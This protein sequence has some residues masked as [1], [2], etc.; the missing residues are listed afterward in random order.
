M[1]TRTD[2]STAGE[3]SASDPVGP[4][5]DTN[6]RSQRAICYPETKQSTEQHFPP[7]KPTY[8]KAAAD[9]LAGQLLDL[10]H[11][12]PG[13]APND[14]A[15]CL[16]LGRGL[17]E[18]AKAKAASLVHSSRFRDFIS[19]GDTPDSLL[20]NGRDDLGAVEG[21]SPLSLVAAELVH[22]CQQARTVFTTSFFCDRRRFK[23]ETT[24]VGSPAVGLMSSL[25]G[26]ILSQM[27]QRG[28]V[29]NLAFLTKVDWHNVEKLK[30][31]ILSIIF[32]E[33]INQLPAGSVLVCVIDEVSLYET[34]LHE[35]E[36]D[37][38]VRRLARLSVRNDG[39]IFKL[40]VACR[41]RP[42]GVGR[43]FLGKTIDL[44]EQVET[45]D[46]A[47]SQVSKLSIGF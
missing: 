15:T 14:V 30:L 4:P 22:R 16:R 2:G 39:L 37:A 10:L 23:M 47:I 34:A 9:Q 36:T 41:G 5:I 33:L 31:V 42:V 28:I 6:R 7:T 27:L 11:Y 20:V 24:P 19:A 45:N 3:S 8:V 1:G 17:D 26:Q 13:L 32:R 44:D 43:Y 29:V 25:V 46:S 40:L 21:L 35:K 12:D 18:Q 38:V